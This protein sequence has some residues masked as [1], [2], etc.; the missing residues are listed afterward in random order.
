MKRI[1]LILLLASAFTLATF[2]SGYKQI[3]KEPKTENPTSPLSAEELAQ[4]QGFHVWRG[5]APFNEPCKKI[6]V[7]VVKP[8]NTRVVKFSMGMNPPTK[9]N[10]ILVGFREESGVY[11]GNI[12]IRFSGYTSVG[13]LTFTNEPTEYPSVWYG[14]PSPWT[15]STNVYQGIITHY[16]NDTERGGDDGSF[17]AI[18]ATK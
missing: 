14:G 5:A 10:N 18:E 17:L 6:Q 15:V 3:Q 16:Y 13:K 4:L 1:I 2:F 9:W 7:V 8:D 11:S 12:L